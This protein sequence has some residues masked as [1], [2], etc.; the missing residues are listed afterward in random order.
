MRIITFPGVDFQ[1]FR[2]FLAHHRLTSN[3]IL[4]KMGHVLPDRPV[5]PFLNILDLLCFEEIIYKTWFAP[6]SG[7]FLNGW[8]IIFAHP[9]GQTARYWLPVHVACLEPYTWKKIHVGWCFEP[10][11]NQKMVVSWPTGLKNGQNST[12]RDSLT[13]R[14]ILAQL[15][16]KTR[17]PKKLLT[18]SFGQAFHSRVKN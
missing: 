13:W 15:T 11:R 14:K 10:L 5:F 4:P 18:T 1:N 3:L 16:C 8:Y 9:S 17:G 6:V 12:S 2:Y 7:G